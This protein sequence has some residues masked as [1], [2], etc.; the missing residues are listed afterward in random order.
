MYPHSH[1]LSVLLKSLEEMLTYVTASTL[2]VLDTSLHKT[3]TD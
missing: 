2:A 3:L 1:L